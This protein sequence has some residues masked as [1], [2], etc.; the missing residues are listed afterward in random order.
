MKPQITTKQ[1]LA[2]KTIL[3]NLNDFTAR[4]LGT[5]DN[6]TLMT[7]K[8]L[9]N[10]I[11]IK[12]EKNFVTEGQPDYEFKIAAVAQDGQITFIQDKLGDIFVK[13]AFLSECMPF[14]FEDKTAYDKI[15]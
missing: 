3:T 7:N 14:D 12:Y 15:D 10:N 9:P 2:T 6:L 13:S 11:L 5:I 4:G 8:G 1:M